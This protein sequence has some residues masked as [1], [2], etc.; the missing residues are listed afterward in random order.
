MKIEGCH[1]CDD[2][3]SS[4]CLWVIVSNAFPVNECKSCQLKLLLK[5]LCDKML[6]EE[7]NELHNIQWWIKFC[8]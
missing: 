3:R 8:F 6:L 5:T 7:N 4:M 1:M 2:P